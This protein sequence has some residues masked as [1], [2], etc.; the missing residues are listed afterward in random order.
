MS[1][2]KLSDFD[3]WILSE[4]HSLV[5][6]HY[7]DQSP[8]EQAIKALRFAQAILKLG[9]KEIAP[10]KID[11]QLS[12]FIHFLMD[13]KRKKFE[14]QKTETDSLKFFRAFT[15]TG[16]LKEVRSSSRVT[17]TFEKAKP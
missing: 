6:N 17:R 3:E 1:K 15:D 4:L 2:Y 8:Q 13:S 11:E 10:R 7:A 12:H 14:V 5:S 9:Y 16:L